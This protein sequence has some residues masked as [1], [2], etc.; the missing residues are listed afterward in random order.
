M[1][2]NWVTREQDWAVREPPADREGAALAGPP[3][4]GDEDQGSEDG[5]ASPDGD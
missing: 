2:S 5:E 3:P 1:D 4:A